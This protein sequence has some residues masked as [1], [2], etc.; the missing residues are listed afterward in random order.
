MHFVEA[1]NN[2]TEREKKEAHSPFLKKCSYFLIKAE[3]ARQKVK[4][5]QHFTH[6]TAT[7]LNTYKRY[8]K[9]SCF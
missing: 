7:A 8:Q 2:V 6:K 9:V 3:R 5:N 4:P 1:I